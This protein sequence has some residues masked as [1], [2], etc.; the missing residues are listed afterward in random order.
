MLDAAENKIVGK[1]CVPDFFLSLPVSRTLS[2]G[3]QTEFREEVGE[4]GDNLRR[5]ETLLN[6][7]CL[8]GMEQV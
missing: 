3:L 1:K 4:I 6:R 7:Y 2:S 8:E 5:I